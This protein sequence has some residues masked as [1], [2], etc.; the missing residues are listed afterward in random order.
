MGKV[1]FP[2]II[3]AVIGLIGFLLYGLVGIIVGAAV[4]FG[5][6]TYDI[7]TYDNYAEHYERNN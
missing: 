2:I 3:G 1:L 6:I 7:I 4:I 5:L